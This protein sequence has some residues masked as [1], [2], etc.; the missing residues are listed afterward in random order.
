MELGSR[1]PRVVRLRERLAQAHQRVAQ[2]LEN[3][4][5]E[6]FC[7]PKA[8]MFLWARHPE[9]QNATELAYRAAEQDILL[10]PGHLFA[11]DLAHCEALLAR[12]SGFRRR[13]RFP[14]LKEG[15]TLEITSEM[16]RLTLAVVGLLESMMTAQIVDDLTDTPSDKNRDCV[17]QGVSN[18]AAGF[19]GGMAGCAMI[20]QSVINVTMDM[21]MTELSEI[22][23]T[24]LGLEREK[25]AL[26]YTVQEVKGDERGEGGEHGRE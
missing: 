7:E 1:D 20:G 13:F 9:I 8:G 12:H 2:Q 18:I 16:T 3:L 17:G 10:G 14:L 24:A 23:V 21:E 22:V 11:P 4:G 19:L 15:E 5:F 26:G 6:L 25:K